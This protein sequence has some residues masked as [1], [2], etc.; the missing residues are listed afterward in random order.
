MDYSKSINVSK[1]KKRYQ[2][3]DILNI[4]AC[5]CVVFMH[6]NGIVHSYENTRAW[7][8]SMIVETL[9]YW[10]VPVFFMISGATLLGYREKYSTSVFLKKRLIKTVIPFFVWT[11]I[12][13]VFKTAAGLMKPDFSAG[14]IISMFNNTTVENVYWFFIP[15]FMVYLS[16]PVVSL[17]KENRR[18]LIYTACAAFLIYSVY[19]MF[20]RFTG[21]QQNSAVIFP[22]AGGYLLY[23]VLGYILST[24]EYSR[25]TRIFVYAAGIFGIAVRYG[26]TVIL[27]AEKGELA[28]DFW[29][30]LNFPAVL[31]SAAVFLMARHIPWEKIFR[32]DKSRKIVSQIAGAGFGVY[33]MHMIVYR[34]LEHLTGL[35]A[36]T[37]VW[38]F[39]MPF[40]IYFICVGAV[41]IIKKIPGLRHIVP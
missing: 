15:L 19:P 14:G 39:G 40:V 34:I 35:G 8:E 32:T 31:L 7:K 18:V 28:E 41:L 1:G 16:M 22:A 30:Y 29:G 6:C 10:A 37:Y 3:I 9:A 17:L 23:T 33:L 38:R 13:V 5:L 4:L 20:C 2:Y 12:N 11:V 25:G 21:V 27:S 26:S 36:H 24:G